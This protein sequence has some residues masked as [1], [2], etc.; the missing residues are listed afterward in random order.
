MIGFDYEYRI[1]PSA[2][3]AAGCS[4]VFRYTMPQTP[5]WVKALRN[6]EAAE[7]LGAGFPVVSNFE[8]SADRMRGGAA[9]G[10]EDALQLVADWSALGA[11]RGLVG[12][13]S[14]DW[15]VQPSEVAACLAYLNAAAVVLGG[16]RYVGCYGGFRVCKAAADGGFGIWQTVAWSR[17]Q[18]DP[19]AAARQT[20]GQRTVGGVS[21]DVNV[22]ANLAGLGAWM[23][24]PPTPTPTTGDD[25]TPQDIK[26]IAAAV[27]DYGREDIT[28]PGGTVKNAPLGQL[29]HGAWVAVNDPKS[30]VLSGMAAIRAEQ[31]AGFAALQAKG[32]DTAALAA[33]LGP[34]IHPEMD[35]NALAAV[36]I[37][38]LPGSPD[39]GAFVTE[40]LAHVRVV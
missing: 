25:V 20:G 33:A 4:V 18:W 32:T 9:A 5:Y 27:Y 34:L 38:H 24:V 3:R 13:F 16:R 12:W 28:V 2:L 8:S 30:P 1:A 29:A 19:R 17:G 10:R 14:A 22:I 39:P 37:P 26:D 11:P 31:A 35:V 36:L 7:L 15:D 23:P 6:A 21:V 40:L